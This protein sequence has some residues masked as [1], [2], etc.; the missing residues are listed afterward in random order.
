MES[1]VQPS[2]HSH[3]VETPESS[4]FSRHHQQFSPKRCSCSIERWK[5]EGVRH[6][7]QSSRASATTLRHNLDCAGSWRGSTKHGRRASARMRGA[8]EAASKAAEGVPSIR[9]E[10]AC[11]QREKIRPRKRLRRDAGDVRAEVRRPHEGDRLPTGLTASNAAG[12][13]LF[14]QKRSTRPDPL[15]HATPPPGHSPRSLAIACHE[16][17]LQGAVHVSSK[18]TR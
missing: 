10:T 3:T 7:Q 15:P 6:D 4:Q 2:A 1:N 12:I 11:T 9:F 13:A 8:S 18:E 16:A 17:S 5:A 14:D